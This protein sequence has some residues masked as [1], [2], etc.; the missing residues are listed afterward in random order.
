MPI[1]KS[2]HVY[3]SSIHNCQNLEAIKKSFSRGIDKLKSIRKMHYYSA[4]KKLFT[5]YEKTCKNFKC[6]LPCEKSQSEK[7]TYCMLQ[8]I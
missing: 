2:A 5:Q 6:L 1:Q 3:N 4:L 7:A 8:N